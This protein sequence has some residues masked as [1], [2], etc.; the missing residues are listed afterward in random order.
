MRYIHWRDDFSITES[1]ST[2]QGSSPVPQRVRIEYF[3]ARGRSRFVAER[4]GNTFVNCELSGGG[5]TLTVH[6]SLRDKPIG[7]GR[8]LRIATVITEDPHFPGGLKYSSYPGKL[9]AILYFGKSDGP[10]DLASEIV[11]DGVDR[12]SLLQDV[13]LS[14]PA[15]GDLLSWNGSRWTNIPQ[16]AIRQDLSGYVTWEDMAD[17]VTQDDLQDILSR[18]DP[19]DELSS[20]SSRISALEDAQFFELDGNGGVKLKDEYAG[21]WSSSW[22]AF[23]GIGTGGGGGGGDASYLDD[24]LDV[25][26]PSPSNGD[27]LV[28]NGSEWVNSNDYYTKAQV[29]TSL[30]VNGNYLTWTKN[31]VSSNITI[32]FATSALK[33]GNGNTISETYAQASAINEVLVRLSALEDLFESVDGAVHVKKGRAFYADNW[34][35]F[36]GIGTQGG[37][38]GGAS[39]LDDLE[40][41]EAQSPSNG[42]F[43]SWDSTSHSW[44][45]LHRPTTL[46]GYGIT[47]AYTK[48]EIN[49]MVGDL[50]VIEAITTSQDGTVDFTW[51]N[52]DIVKVDLNHQHS[53]YVPITRTINGHALSDNI[54]LSAT[55][56]LGVAEWAMGGTGSTI[57][58]NRL[59]AMY[60]AGAAVT[61]ARAK[62]PLITVGAISNLLS[63]GDSDSSRIEWDGA[64]WHFRGNIYADGWIV[65][66]GVGNEDTLYLNSSL[67]DVSVDEQ[68]L[69]DGDVLRWNSISQ[70]WENKVIDVSASPATASSLGGVMVVPGG[71][72]ATPLSI[73]SVTS[74]SDRYY[75]VLVDSSGLAFVNVPWSGGGGASWGAHSS[76][77]HTIELTVNGVS[78]VLCENGYAAGGGVSSES[79][80]V[81]TASPAY[82]LD[83]AHVTALMSDNFALKTGESTY[84]FLVNTLKF[85]IGTIGAQNYMVNQESKPR[86]KWTY[87]YQPTISPQGSSVVTETKYLAYRDEIPTS[88][89]NPYEIWFE[90]VLGYVKYDGSRRV[91]ISAATLDAVT[92]AGTQTITGEKTM[93]E[94][95]TLVK[96]LLLSAS[97]HIDIGPLRIEYD[98]DAKALHITKASAQDPNN[99]GIYTDGILIGGGIQE[100]TT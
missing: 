62:A 75:P 5:T 99:Y 40:D 26:A 22:G 46:S 28:W 94:D 11:F 7:H 4:N 53:N 96:D 9:E 45:N 41:V 87:S 36:G 85:S 6:I 2:A 8:L 64:A 23:G 81:F 24:L 98:A 31:G 89:K 91:I 68:N 95:L 14:N 58:F 48:A 27:L 69:F 18:L 77:A 80:P 30:G 88:L 55:T 33:D 92:L 66:G 90:G 39:Y 83:S 84:N 15:E 49:S 32:P 73:Q 97:S 54:T 52:G 78:Y 50:N 44:V 71:V 47:D 70:K 76:T 1:F 57:P 12:L 10:L 63:S 3:T 72:V 51:R 29:V 79:D 82:S 13:N 16:S 25:D 20:L 60:V 67:A 21:L 59:P 65:A 61:S 38:G 17:Y 56:D 43:L 19:T 86:L 100:Q 93:E 34:G 37:G 74:V 42:D 35:A